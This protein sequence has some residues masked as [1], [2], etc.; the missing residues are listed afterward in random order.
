M[1]C[2]IENMWLDAVMHSAQPPLQSHDALQFVTPGWKHGYILESCLGYLST[3]YV[4]IFQEE[5]WLYLTIQDKFRVY[6]GCGLWEKGFITKSILSIEDFD[7]L[8]I[9]GLYRNVDEMKRK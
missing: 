9:N 5:V 4:E 3:Q 7:T 6:S 8:G 2:G 1:H